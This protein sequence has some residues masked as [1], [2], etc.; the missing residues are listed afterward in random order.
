MNHWKERLKNNLEPLLGE[1]DPRPKISSYHDMPYAIFVYPPEDEFEL[2]QELSKLETR[3]ENLGKRVTR[4]SLAECLGQAIADDGYTAEDLA[5]AERT[6]G[7]DKTLDTVHSILADHSPEDLIA[8]RIPDDAD[9]LRDVVLIHRAG[10]LYPF[11]RTSTLLEPM[12]GKVTVPAVLFYPGH[13]VGA[14]GLSFMGLME[15][16]HN[17]RPKKF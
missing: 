7:L 16:Q 10:A 12:K 11:Y 17:Y 2:R 6:M 8:E 3:L 4:I 9:P 15:A 1:N 13:E 14:A 5:Q